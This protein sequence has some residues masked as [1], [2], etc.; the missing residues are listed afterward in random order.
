MAEAVDEAGGGKLAPT[1]NLSTG[2]YSLGRRS[3]TSC[4]SDGEGIADLIG[5]LVIR[6]SLKVTGR[7][8]SLSSGK[9]CAHTDSGPPLTTLQHP[10][11]DINILR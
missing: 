6:I 1:S 3:S 10:G 7:D 11:T 4:N 2:A 8:N 5:P 9:S